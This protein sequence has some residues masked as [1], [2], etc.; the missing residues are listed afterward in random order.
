MATLDQSDTM[1]DAIPTEP[2]IHALL[3]LEEDNR[4]TRQDAEHLATTILRTVNICS[5]D[6]VKECKDLILEHIIAPSSSTERIQVLCKY[7]LALSKS[8]VPREPTELVPTDAK[9]QGFDG[10]GKIVKGKLQQPPQQAF[11]CLHLLYIVHDLLLWFFEHSF[12]T[13]E[14]IPARAAI[15]DAI[16]I[17]IPA[18][19]GLAAFRGSPDCASTFELVVD[20]LMI[21]EER[22]VFDMDFLQSLESTA[23][24]AHTESKGWHVLLEYLLPDAALYDL[25]LKVEKESEWVVPLRH[26]LPGDPQ[27]PWHELPAANGLHMRR[28]YGHPLQPRAFPIGGYNLEDGGKKANNDI[29]SEVKHLYSELLHCFDRHIVPDDVQDIDALGNVIWKDPQR[30]TRNHWGHSYNAVEKRREVAQQAKESCVGYGGVELQPMHHPEVRNLAHA[31]GNVMGS[32]PRPQHGSGDR[33]GYANRD[34]AMETDSARNVFANHERGG[35]NRETHNNRGGSQSRG[36]YRGRGGRPDLPAWAGIGRTGSR[37]ALVAESLLYSSTTVRRTRDRNETLFRECIAAVTFVLHAGRSTVSQIL[38]HPTRGSNY[39]ASNL[40][41][42][43]ILLSLHIFATAINIMRLSTTFAICTALTSNAVAYTSS[44]G[45][46]H[47]D[48][49]RPKVIMDNDW[50]T[51][52]FIPILQAL[53][54][55]WEILG[56]T[57]ST[58]NSWAL[59]CGLHALATLEVGNLSC[60]PVYKGSDYPLINHPGLFQSWQDVHGDLPWQGAFAM[61]N[62]TYEAEGND[63]TSG[64]PARIS[65]S[66]F[67]EGYPNTTFASDISAA[68]FMV[69][70]VRRYPGEISIYAAGAMTNIALAVRLDSS[71]AQNAKELVVMGGY[72]DVNVLQTTGTVLLADLQSDINLMIDPEASKIALT[73]A[74]P[75]ITIAG[76]V[77]NQVSSTQSFL[78]D[79][80]QVRNPYTELIYNYYGTEFPF[81][82]ETAAAIMLDS[83]LVK[84]ATSFYVD[85]DVSYASPQYGNIHAYQKALK[86][87][88]QNLREVNYVLEVDGDVL[89]RGIRESLQNPASCR[90]WEW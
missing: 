6:N 53:H 90:D 27:A 40:Y 60:I 50:S 77:A 21:W 30:E 9:D 58:S 67:K 10:L 81:W 8:F 45:P 28:T 78:D 41:S 64:D 72:I 31:R 75:N 20:I 68:E 25:T 71:F 3:I 76:N 59:Q 34:S 7:L 1:E 85:V 86:P 39:L 89:K 61:E 35:P 88:A 17:R 47:V 73:A 74:F 42:A 62:L 16:K 56:V 32:R 38:L 87:R 36:G 5:Q 19:V 80:H 70:Q 49:T 4:I 37:Q 22:G 65:T 18:L 63:P 2:F 55:G 43:E 57:S 12:D 82:D 11:R 54:A 44:N 26:G 66:A 52:G 13:Q 83:S 48:S 15:I 29:I 84:N 51:V 79:I 14:I 69:Q 23:S 24:M 46:Q 33:G